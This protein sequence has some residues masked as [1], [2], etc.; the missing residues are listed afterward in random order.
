MTQI[1][2]RNTLSDIVPFL[3]RSSLV[4]GS[5]KEPADNRWQIGGTIISWEACVSQEEIIASFWEWHINNSLDTL[6]SK[7]TNWLLK[8]IKNIL[9]TSLWKLSEGSN[10]TYRKVHLGKS[11]KFDQNCLWFWIPDG[12]QYICYQLYLQER[13]P[14]LPWTPISQVKKAAH[15]RR[16]YLQAIHLTEDS[17]LG[18]VRDSSDQQ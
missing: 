13:Y 10:D 14:G 5:T 18:Y 12:L 11:A 7:T 17:Y 1:L 16:A 4:A 3:L 6:L 15:Q 8:F 2:L 9:L